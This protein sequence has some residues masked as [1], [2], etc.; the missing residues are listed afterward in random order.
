[1]IDKLIAFALRQKS[2]ALLV[3]LVYA[4]SEFPDVTNISG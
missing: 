1:M 3:F 2:V 4:Y